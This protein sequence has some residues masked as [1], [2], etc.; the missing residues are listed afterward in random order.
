MQRQINNI[1]YTLTQKKVKNINLRVKPSG[2]VCVSSNKQIPLVRIDE[3][4]LSKSEW[5]I[6]AKARAQ[7]AM[8]IIN[9]TDEECL[10]IF[11]KISDMVYP[12]FANYLKE[13]PEIK[14]KT[15]KSCWGVCHFKKGYI[16]LNKALIAKPIEAIEYVVLHEYVHFIEHNHQKGFHK[17][18]A[19]LMP[20]YKERKKVL[21]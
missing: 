8:P 13:K 1:I 2:E 6:N 20:N 5:I 12:L 19:S 15:L 11:N 10:A 3:F 4:V 16:T 9:A 18:M 14:V 7:K 17:I 21:K